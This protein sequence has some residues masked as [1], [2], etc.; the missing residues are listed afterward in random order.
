MY[1]D[2]VEVR[3]TKRNDT[4]IN[5]LNNLQRR[6]TDGVTENRSLRE[7]AWACIHTLVIPYLPGRE[8]DKIISLIHKE[9]F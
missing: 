1:A 3:R 7:C 9:E 6:D 4:T 8:I 5:L 2:P